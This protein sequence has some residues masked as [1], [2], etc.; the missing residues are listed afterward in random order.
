MSSPSLIGFAL[1]FF[2]VAALLYIQSV[3]SFVDVPADLNRA[4]ISRPIETIPTSQGS[5]V[6]GI[7]AQTKEAIAT[8]SELAELDS[9]LMTWLD[10]ASQRELENPA[11]LTGEQREQRVLYQARISSLRQQLGTGLIVDKSKDVSTETLRIRNENAGWQVYPINIDTEEFARGRSTTAFLTTEEYKQFRGIMIN[12][13]Q[14]L[15]GYVQPDPLT[16]VRMKQL[17][18]IDAELRVV[19]NKN[20]VPLIRVEAARQFLKRMTQPTQ[21][22]PSLMSMDGI[23]EPL[24]TNPVDIIRQVQI[25]PNP[26]PYLIQLASYL[27]SGRASPE[28]I[29]AARDEVARADPG[30]ANSW[31]DYSTYRARAYDPSNYVARAA[32]LCKQIKRAFPD[33]EDSAALGC[34]RHMPTTNDTAE[35]LVYNVC[36]R[37]RESIPTV[38]PKQFNCP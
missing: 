28:Q 19:D 20:R 35:T 25:I 6:P 26:P 33:P 10:A 11:A 31:V 24:M 29:I 14:T 4:P 16:L 1:A 34:P 38:S 37:I 23:Y 21:P 9:K 3:E 7:Q 30:I 27:A 18:S 17:E 15:Q 8:R 12:T 13:L 5:R 2:V 36:Q 32:V 22:L